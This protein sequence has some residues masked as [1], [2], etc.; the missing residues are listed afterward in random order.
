VD[1]DSPSKIEN[2]EIWI[3]N[4]ENRLASS[5]VAEWR[6]AGWVHFGLALSVKISF[7]YLELIV[8]GFVDYT[9]EQGIL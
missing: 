1:R 8:S 6:I 9:D 4:Q 7:T 3:E 2:Q 5:L